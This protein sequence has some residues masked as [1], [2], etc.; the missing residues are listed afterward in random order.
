[1]ASRNQDAQPVD[2]ELEDW[3]RDWSLSLSH[4]HP[5]T[6]V[7]TYRRGVRQFLGWLRANAPAVQSPGQVT[8][9]HVDGWLASLAAAGRSD[10]TRRVRLMT[11]R[12]WFGWIGTEPGNDLDGDPTAHVP[13]PMPDLPPLR[14]VP[15]ADLRRVLETCEGADFVDLRDAA[16]IRLLVA[17]GLRRAE[18]VGIDVT[19]YDPRT[20]DVLV[21][22]KGGKDRWVSVSGTKTPLA[23][24]R[25]LRVR[26]RHPGAANPALFLTLR[27]SASLEWRLSGGGVAEMLRRRCKLAG[28]DPIHP[29]ELRH[30]WADANKRAGLSDEDL[31]RMGGWS[32][33]GMVKRYG[34]ALADDRAR[35]NHRRAGTGDR[36]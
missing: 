19:D 33:P 13:A 7:T 16:M 11:L 15:D 24:S 27:P 31:E 30:A 4:R 1:M 9:R 2:D 21:H 6:T 22:G 29:H 35:D 12:A 14:A 32:T 23:L 17:C 5:Q 34:R 28:V 20:N 25:Y 10:S 18:L 36:I 26:R 8:V 3:L